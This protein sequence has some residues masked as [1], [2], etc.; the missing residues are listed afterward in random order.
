MWR[1]ASNTWNWV[2]HGM[3]WRHDHC[4]TEHSVYSPT[5]VAYK[6]LNT[7]IHSYVFVRE[8]RDLDNTVQLAT[9]RMPTLVC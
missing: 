8:E 5:G 1:V 4:T 2:L 6:G 9:R 7:E 3:E